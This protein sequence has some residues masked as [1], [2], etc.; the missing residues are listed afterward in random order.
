MNEHEDCHV[1]P[2]EKTL[3]GAALQTAQA[4]MLHISGVDCARCATRVRNS[5]LLQQGV[6][7]AEV[8]LEYGVATVAYDP[9]QMKPDD[10]VTAVTT[11]GNDGRHHYQAR[12]W[13]SIPAYQAVILEV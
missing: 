5:L 2:V 13:R 6:L 10:L 8:D 12:V 9:E 1:E 7:Y 4:V 3:D 11:A